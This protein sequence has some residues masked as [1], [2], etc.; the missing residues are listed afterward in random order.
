MP[1]LTSI[2]ESSRPAVRARRPLRALCAALVIASQLALPAPI[3]AQQLPGMGDGGEMTAT[4]ERHLGDQIARELYRDPDYIDDPV[5]V[6]Y[7]QAIWQPLLAAARLRGELT[8][9]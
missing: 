6:D 3:R 4:A 1:R 7:V 8:P 2:S 9:E 5:L